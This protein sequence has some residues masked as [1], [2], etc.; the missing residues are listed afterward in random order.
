MPVLV[1]GGE[2]PFREVVLGAAAHGPG[3]VVVPVNE[4]IEPMERLRLGEGR[5]LPEG[6]RREGENSRKKREHEGIIV[7][8][9]PFRRELCA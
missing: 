2:V 4:R 5:F 6:S 8:F 7:V 1:S 9:T 3:K